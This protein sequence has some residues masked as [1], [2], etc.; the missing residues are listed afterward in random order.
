MTPT[1]PPPQAGEGRVG[2]L[3]LRLKVWRRRILH[4]VV[5][6]S[7]AEEQSAGGRL[8]GRLPP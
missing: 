5:S 4:V 8:V 7:R 2:L 6:L 3:V 1:L